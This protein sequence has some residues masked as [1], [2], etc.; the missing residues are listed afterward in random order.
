MNKNF[1]HGFR[2]TTDAGAKRQK[3]TVSNRKMPKGG[4]KQ[5]E[6]KRH[7][8]QK[9]DDIVSRAITELK[10]R[11]L[12]FFP[13]RMYIH[14]ISR[15]NE[16]VKNI[17]KDGVTTWEGYVRSRSGFSMSGGTIFFRHSELDPNFPDEIQI[18][19]VDSNVKCPCNKHHSS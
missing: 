4:D 9:Y 8:E 12:N 6:L 2:D 19:V 1:F 10:K 7:F 14:E 17:E 5:F 13:G 15:A 3:K 18:S 16:A 11:N